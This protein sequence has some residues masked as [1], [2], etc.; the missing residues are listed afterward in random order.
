MFLIQTNRAPAKR[1]TSA[2]RGAPLD[3][4]TSAFIDYDGVRRC[5]RTAVSNGHIVHPP[6]DT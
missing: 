4:R 3:L 5:L 6:S 2:P 1:Y